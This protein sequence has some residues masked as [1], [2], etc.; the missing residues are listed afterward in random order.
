MALCQTNERKLLM[1]FSA[2]IFSAHC[3]TL[4]C[5]TFLLSRQNFM[6]AARSGNSQASPSQPARLPPN[7]STTRVTILTQR[8][9]RLINFDF[10]L[11]FSLAQLP[12]R[13]EH[14]FMCR[15]NISF[16]KLE[17]DIQQPSLNFL[18]L[19]LSLL[20]SQSLSPPVSHENTQ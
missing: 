15:G 8:R 13:S 1:F 10:S 9:F 19:L 6:A 12:P 7:L 4:K 5:V 14:S 20:E 17:I 16:I 18:L 11:S 2:G 3:E